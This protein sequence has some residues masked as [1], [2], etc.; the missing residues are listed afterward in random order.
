MQKASSPDH[1]WTW[2]FIHDRTI[3]GHSLKMLNLV[4]EYTRECLALVVSRSI[5][6]QDAISILR[7]QFLLRG[8]PVCIRSD[9]GPEFIAKAIRE[10]LDV[11][12]VDTLYVAPGSPWENGYAEAFH[13]VYATSF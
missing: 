13:S 6:A 5:T 12:S 9:N 7:E 11:S 4:D 10:W 1:V 3:K 8:S 2:D